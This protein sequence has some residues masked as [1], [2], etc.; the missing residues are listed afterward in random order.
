MALSFCV[1]SGK[2]GA[3]V[4]IERL[5][6]FWLRIV[7]SLTNCLRRASHKCYKRMQIDRQMV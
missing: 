7:P 2:T 5:T 4:T 3:A 6:G 1:A